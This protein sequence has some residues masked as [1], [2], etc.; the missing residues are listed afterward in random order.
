LSDQGD[1][2][3]RYLHP[4]VLARIDR[5]DIV[6]RLAAECYIYG[7]HRS[8]RSGFSA[9]FSDYRKYCPGDDVSNID[10]RVFARLEK[11]YM[12]C[13]ES[14]TSVRCVL[15]LDVS[16]SMSYKSDPKLV[17]KGEYAGYLAA[18]IAYLLFRQRDRIGLALLDGKL[19]SLIPPKS[20]KSHL[21]R[22]L[23]MISSGVDKPIAGET[24]QALAELAS[25]SRQ[26]GMT[27]VISDL[28]TAKSEELMESLER[29]AF[30]CGDVL[31]LHVLD[32]AEYSVTVPVGARVRDPE[33]GAQVNMDG[34]SAVRCRELLHGLV[35]F[36]RD[37]CA[38]SGIDYYLT[39][40]DSPYDEVLNAFLSARGNRSK[41]GKRSAKNRR[42]RSRA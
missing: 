17:S 9:E 23:E 22:I 26:R 15:A 39:T 32:P 18:V 27:I 42:Q 8:M 11:Y 35:E 14:E 7:L 10:W 25:N 28:L 31:L 4:S 24:S 19:R 2:V 33:T 38:K 34:I 36:Y 13:F 5:L 16:A 3:K 6:S 40:T 1:A 21:Y 29:L 37:R 30:S 12:K 41:R 20:R